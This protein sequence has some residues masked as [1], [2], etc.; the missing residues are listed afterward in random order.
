MSSVLSTVVLVKDTQNVAN[1]TEIIKNLHWW[2]A[3]Q[4]TNIIQHG[5]VDLRASTIKSKIAE[6]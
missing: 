5:G 4:L 3:D 1:R 2:E 6:G